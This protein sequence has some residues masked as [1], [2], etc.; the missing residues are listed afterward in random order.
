MYVNDLLNC[1]AF[2]TVLYA[3]DTYVSLSHKNLYILQYVVNS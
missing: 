1:S 3:D 2:K